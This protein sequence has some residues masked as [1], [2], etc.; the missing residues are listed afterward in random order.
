MSGVLGIGGDVERALEGVGVASYVLDT[1]GVI[2]WLNPAAERLVGDV[3]GQHFV[4]VVA[5]EDRKRAFDLFDRKVLG[6]TTVQRCAHRA[7]HVRD[8][9]AEAGVRDAQHAAV[10]VRELFL[11][12][13]NRMMLDRSL[14]SRRLPGCPALKLR[15]TG[16]GQRTGGDGDERE[17]RGDCMPR[18]VV[19]RAVAADRSECTPACFLRGPNIS[20]SVCSRK[21]EGCSA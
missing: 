14:G 8:R 7:A 1:T 10:Q 9:I 12:C 4:S 5:P 13:V 19:A 11:A 21:K 16:D 20:A 2:R 3:R 18:V 6:A 15:R 17:P